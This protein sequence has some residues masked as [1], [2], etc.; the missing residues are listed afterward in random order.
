MQGYWE[1]NVTV[2]IVDADI[3]ELNMSLHDCIVM[4]QARVLT[5]HTGMIADTK[6]L[7]YRCES[8]HA[9]L[10][11][12][13]GWLIHTRCQNYPS[14]DNIVHLVLLINIISPCLH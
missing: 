14:I 8:L 9:Q 1:L 3:G 12:S 5:M 13:P 6:Q 4:M 7:Y 10:S 11:S 2:L